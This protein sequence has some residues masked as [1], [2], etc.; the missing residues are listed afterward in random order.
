M[1]SSFSSFYRTSV[2]SFAAA[3]AALSA[4]A[5]LAGCSGDANPVRDTFVAVGAGPKTAPMPDF[6]QKSRTATPLD[7]VP[8]GT[9]APERPSVAKTADQVKAAEAEMDA[10]RSHNEAAG[11]VATQVGATPPPAP[12]TGAPPRSAA[13]AAKKK[14]PAAK[15]E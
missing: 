12:V 4:M 9:T 10:T 2:K 7:Y 15:A 14:A 5:L 6:V 3:A 13:S 11:R 1:I 8:V